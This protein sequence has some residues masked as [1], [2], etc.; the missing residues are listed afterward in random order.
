VATVLGDLASR[1]CVGPH[2]K[3]SCGFKGSPCT[4][5]RLVVAKEERG[6]GKGW[7]GVLGAADINCYI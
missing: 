6:M 2:E 3:Q 1:L 5:N 7:D 4:E